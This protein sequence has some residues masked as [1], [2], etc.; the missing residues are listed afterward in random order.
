MSNKNQRH[1]STSKQSQTSKL[2][3]QATNKTAL[4]NNK[5]DVVEI[6]SGDENNGSVGVVDKDKS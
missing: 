5:I 2:R 4:K 3:K 6:D 1:L